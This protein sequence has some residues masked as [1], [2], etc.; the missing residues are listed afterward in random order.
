MRPDFSRAYAQIK[1]DYAIPDGVMELEFTES[2][3]FGNHSL[4]QSIVTECKRN[5]FL[6]S[7]DDFGAGYSSLNLLKSIYADVL[8]LDGL[9]FRQGDKD[10]N[11]D[12]GRELVKNIVAMAKSLG[13]KTVAEGVDTLEQVEQLREIGCDAVQ[14]YVFAKPLPTQD[15]ERFFESWQCAGK[16]RPSSRSLCLADPEIPGLALTVA[17]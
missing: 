1:D 6:C 12:R 10:T 2:L 11:D 16:K 14:G 7:L 13:M 5:G 9:F 4:L 17:P 15:F 8:K 3:A